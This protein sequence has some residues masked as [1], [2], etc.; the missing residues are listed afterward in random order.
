MEIHKGKSVIDIEAEKSSFK[1]M[2][3]ILTTRSDFNST[4]VGCFKNTE[5]A[6]TGL[7]QWTECQLGE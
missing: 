2:L 1:S 6:K 4:L 3:K 7:T 5:I